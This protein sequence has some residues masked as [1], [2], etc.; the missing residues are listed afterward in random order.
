MR[1]LH[2]WRTFPPGS[3]SRVCGHPEISGNFAASEAEAVDG[4]NGAF[5]ASFTF[6]G[7]GG[8][9]VTP[10]LS[11][12]MTNLPHLEMISIRADGSGNLDGGRFPF[13]TNGAALFAIPDS[14]DPSLLVFAEYMAPK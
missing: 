10:Q 7:N 2:Y 4:S 6:T 5:L 13:V 9:T 3:N 1:L 12:S 14:D 8:Y 11:G